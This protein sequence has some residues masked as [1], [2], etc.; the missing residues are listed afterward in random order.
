MKL[1]K[2]WAYLDTSAYIKLY[3]QEKGSSKV[4]TIGKTY[5]ILSSA[6]LSLEC[7]SAL[8]RKKQEG[9][10]SNEEFQEIVNRIQKDLVYVEIINVTEEILRKAEEVILHAVSRTLDAIHIASAMLFIESTEIDLLF[11]T[12][13]KQQQ[14]WAITCGLKTLLIE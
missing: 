5:N 7:F 9:Y 8:A 6:L 14:K 11:V 4:I 12:A 13:D 1:R 3:F 10:F 2:Q